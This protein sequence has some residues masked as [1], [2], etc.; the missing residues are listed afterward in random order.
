MKRIFNCAITNQIELLYAKTSLKNFLKSYTT[1]DTH[2]LEF[3]VMELGTNLIKYANGGELWFL[4]I[5]EKLALASV[6]FG[7]GADDIDTIVQ[8]GYSSSAQESLGLGLFSLVSHKSYVFEI[9]S[10]SKKNSTSMAGSIFV[11]YEKPHDKSSF[12]SMSLP[13]YDTRHNGDFIVQKGKYVFFGDI[14]GHGKKA[15][16]SASEIIKQFFESSIVEGYIDDYF[17][18]LHCFII[19]NSL[20]SFVGALVELNQNF[21]KIYGVG[22]ISLVVKQK[23]SCRLNSFSQGIVGET[24]NNVSSFEFFKEE[25][26]MVILMTDGIDAKKA[27]EIVQKFGNLSKES[28]A[29]AITHFAGMHDDK[30][31]AIFI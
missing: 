23:E 2:F 31:V 30:T 18:K 1:P 17:Q 11:L 21:W 29:I 3:A 9:A 28:L 15:F 5:N 7:V 4:L 26:S 25:C 6:D 10:F 27:I 24:F 20:R 19:E 13:L 12:C 14:A 8:R 16:L 22:N